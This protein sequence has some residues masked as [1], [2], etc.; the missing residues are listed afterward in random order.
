LKIATAEVSRVDFM[1][2]G[3]GRLNVHHSLDPAPGLE[4][5]GVRFAGRMS[6]H[7]GMTD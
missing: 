4:N 5:T 3:A 6:T 1:L 2:V 7:T